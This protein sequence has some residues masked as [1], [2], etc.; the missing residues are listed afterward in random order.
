MIKLK[1]CGVTNESDAS[2]LTSMGV[3]FIGLIFVEET[4]RSINLAKAIEIKNQLSKEVKLVGVFKDQDKQLVNR[5]AD[6][7]N[8]DL[9]QLHGQE[10]SQYIEHMERPVIKTID[11][12]PISG[13]I[14]DPAALEELQNCKYLLLDKPKNNKATTNVLKLTKTVEMVSN[15]NKSTFLAG[16]LNLKNIEMLMNSILPFALDICSGIESS[17]GKKSVTKIKQLVELVNQINLHHQS[18][19]DKSPSP[20]W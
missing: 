7:I 16:G 10:S 12:D 4:P 13:K 1:I 5:Y 9:I 6:K 14:I 3:D 15:I 18:S 8:L 19:K 20:V 2:H 11:Y 17:P